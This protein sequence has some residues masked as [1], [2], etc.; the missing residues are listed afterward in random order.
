MTICKFSKFS[1]IPI[2]TI[3][4]RKKKKRRL[5]KV[6]D[7]NAVDLKKFDSVSAEPIG[8]VLQYWER[9]KQG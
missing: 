6:V 5:K 1:E 8:V 4:D 2:L 3:L 7:S 9:Q